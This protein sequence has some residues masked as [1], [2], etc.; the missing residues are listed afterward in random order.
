MGETRKKWTDV[1]LAI[2]YNQVNGICPMCQK[3]LWYE[4]NNQIKKWFEVAHIYPLNPSTEEKE[5]LKN[6]P[7]L[8]DK[9]K[10]DL[11][12]V[13]ALCPNCHT[14]VDNPT[15]LET[16]RKLY[17]LKKKFIDNDKISLLYSSYIIEEDIIK[18]VNAMASGLNND[19]EKIQYDLI[20]VDNKI[21]DKRIVLRN[22]VKFDVSQYYLFIR[23]LFLEIEKNNSGIFDI[24]AGQ[25]KSFYLKIKTISIDQEEI[26]E[27][28][29]EWLYN[30]YKIGTIESYKILV[31]FFIQ[32]CEVF[33][34]VAK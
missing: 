21:D 28:I 24:I 27:H 25:I 8:F 32:N 29:S 22:K 6:E 4:K 1:Q 30:K 10:N 12:N 26:Y 20:K 16:Y 7:V 9:D 34:D 13:I 33:S 31:S 3:V 23:N 5:I 2:L 19:I 15:T 14:Y 11:N 18:I 17:D